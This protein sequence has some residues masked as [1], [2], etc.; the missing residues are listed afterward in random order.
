MPQIRVPTNLKKPIEF[1]NDGNYE[2][3]SVPTK[4]KCL[5]CINEICAYAEPDEPFRVCVKPGRSVELCI[6]AREDTVADAVREAEQ[7]NVLSEQRMNE[8]WNLVKNP[9]QN[10]LPVRHGLGFGF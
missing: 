1:R 9:P 3:W 5:F 8:M 2:L 7:E 6:C 4:Q 10:T